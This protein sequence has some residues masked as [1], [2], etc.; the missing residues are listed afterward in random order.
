MGRTRGGGRASVLWAKQREKWGRP[1]GVV[2]GRGI[3]EAPMRLCAGLCTPR[4][5]ITG[6][7]GGLMCP[8]SRDTPLPP[9]QAR[10]ARGGGN[11]RN[12]STN[13]SALAPSLFAIPASQVPSPHCSGFLGSSTDF[14]EHTAIPGAPCPA[15]LCNSHRWRDKAA[16]QQRCHRGPQTPSQGLQPAPRH[17]ATPRAPTPSPPALMPVLRE[18]KGQSEH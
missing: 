16:E 13:P 17:R 2:G 18:H 7:W 12:K 8:S 3:P 6:P 9:P 15:E 1:M 10:S 5:L 4:Q 14:A 11:T